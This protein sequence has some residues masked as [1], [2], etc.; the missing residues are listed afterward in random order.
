LGGLKGK[1]HSEDLDVDGR[2]LKWIV[3]KY[4]V[5]VWIAFNWL[6]I[7]TYGGLLLTR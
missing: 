3:G 4:G 6:R 2:I 7:G 5:R 1:D